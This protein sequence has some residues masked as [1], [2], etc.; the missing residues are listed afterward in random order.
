MAQHVALQ[1]A[2]PAHAHG[3]IALAGGALNLVGPYHG[4][5]PPE[6]FYRRIPKVSSEQT[7]GG[8]RKVLFLRRFTY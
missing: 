1:E 7:S 5:L 6:C 3:N 8:R 4:C 2:I